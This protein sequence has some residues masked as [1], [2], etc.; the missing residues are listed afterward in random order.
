MLFV[1]V[2]P[3]ILSLSTYLTIEVKR[4]FRRMSFWHMTMVYET[5]I[6]KS[7]ASQMMLGGCLC[8]FYIN[9]SGF[10]LLAAHLD[11]TGIRAL[12]TF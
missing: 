7:H 5:H 6:T 2:S 12:Y 3:T 4:L 1:F 11:S 8:I 10:Y 9:L